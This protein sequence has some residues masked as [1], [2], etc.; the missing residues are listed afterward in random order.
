MIGVIGWKS[1]TGSRLSSGE[2]TG[3]TDITPM[4]VRNSV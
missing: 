4:L 3:L 2:S 1:L